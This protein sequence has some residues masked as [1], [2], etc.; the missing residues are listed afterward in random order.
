M[1]KRI[2]RS[3]L[4]V[5]LEILFSAILLI[6]GALYNY[7]TKVQREQLR[8]ETALIAQGVSLE[9]KNY[10]ENLNVSNVRITWVDNEGTILYDSNSD[11]TKMDN[12]QNRKEIREAMEEGYGESTRFSTTLTT[13][14]IYVAQRLDDGTVLRLSVTQHSLL[15]LLI[16]MF[17]PFA[18]IVIL[19]IVLSIWVA[20][21]TS[22]RIIAPLNNLDLDQPLSNDAYDEITPLLRRIDY[23]Q[24]EL[25]KKESQFNQKKQE[26]DTI[27]SKIKEGIILLDA[28]CHVISMNAAAQ[29]LFQTDQSCIG[30]DILKTTRDLAFNNLLEVGLK[31]DNQEGIVHFDKDS[32]KVLIRPILSDGHMT[33]LV[34]LLFDVTEQLQIEQLRHEFTANVSHELKTPLHVISGYSEMLVNGLV[35]ADDVPRFAGKI[36]KESKQMVQLVEDI[37]KL[38]QL[39]ETDQ[40][41]MEDVDLYRVAKSVLSSLSAKAKQRDIQLQLKGQ[42]THITGNPALIHSVLYNLSDNAITYNR[43]GGSVNITITDEADKISVDVK[44]T[45]IGISK[46]EQE[47]IFE[48]FYRI[49]KSRSRKVGG[50][51]LGL[52][53]VKHA[54]KLHNA[55]INVRSVPDEGTTMTLTFKK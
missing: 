41:P 40:V 50:T 52:S 55:S 24:K 54:L 29:D 7:F 43:D 28:G 1:I 36:Y 30:K 17:Q 4:F 18:L 53:I 5:S 35:S 2:F 34:V 38:S 21:Y 12:H 16:R 14:S 45:G 49:D 26:F 32:Y 37:I 25:A 39:D 3:T 9:G 11:A 15:L 8:T 20:R 10:L 19:S 33:G 22:R 51:G 44:D 47:R 23:H 27:I 42:P 46:E 31:G 48:R 13:Q 6:M